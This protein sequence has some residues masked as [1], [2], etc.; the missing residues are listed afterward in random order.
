MT[1][2]RVWRDCLALA[3]FIGLTVVF[4]YP[5]ALQLGTQLGGAGDDPWIFLWN[6][7]WTKEAL[8]GG[9]SPYWTQYL[10]F[11][12]GASMIFHSFSWPNS[13]LAIG[14][15]PLVGPIAAYNVVLMLGYALSG[16]GTYLLVSYLTGNAGA[17]LVAGTVFAFS[18]YRITQAS[19]PLFVAVGWFPLA[20]LFLIRC[21]REGRARYAVAAGVFTALVGLTAW[22]LL[23]FAAMAMAILV[24]YLL[25]SERSRVNGRTLGLLALAGI[26][27][28]ALVAPA[29]GPLIQVQLSGLAD[30]EIYVRQDERTQT[31]LL[32]YVVPNRLQPVYGHLFTS[33]YDRFQ[34]NRNYVAFLG[35]SVIVLAILGTWYSRRAALPWVLVA[36]CYG[37]MALGPVLR[38]N[39][40]LYPGV[41]MPYR[42]IGWTSFVRL[43]KQ[44]DRFN[45]VLGLPIAVLVGYGVDSLCR[46][47]RD[48]L[49]KRWQWVTWAAC[50]M[51]VA[52]EY[53][54]I[55]MWTIAT[56]YPA[57]VA[58]LRD[59]AGE[60]AV[61]D[62]P[63]GRELDKRYLYYQ[64][65]HERP[66]LGGH[67]SRPLPGTY[68]FIESHSLLTRLFDGR[69]VDLTDAELACEM[70]SLVMSNVRYILLHKG[71]TSAGLEGN[72]RDRLA[73]WQL[74]E[75]DGVVLYAT[76]GPSEIGY[77][78][79][80]S[81][82]P[83]ERQPLVLRDAYGDG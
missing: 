47:W 12:R 70:E 6:N 68:A 41:P 16:W 79:A 35:Y 19:H 43:L 55:P 76:E 59:E 51:L 71:R 23:I 15:E 22:H 54:S 1:T 83:V 73:P 57:T 74:Q 58:R 46:R 25:A 53:V 2:R 31:D 17:A 64:T 5:L 65:I 78:P 45:L 82:C 72:W 11:P 13:L 14:I 29:L 7:W 48:G 81:V 42:L 50:A 67:I 4:T 24:V 62:V 80:V 63:V 77:Y 49:G 39:G 66:I 52:W 56:D 26:V 75:D 38:F 32:A 33:F 21:V 20:L 30:K 34:K 69:V 8:A 27:A 40:R 3:G 28:A 18:P 60:F 10:Y 44:P 9:T 61:L 36:G 37:A